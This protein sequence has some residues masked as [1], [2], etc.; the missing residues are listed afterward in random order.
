MTTP[1]RPPATLIYLHGH[2]DDPQAGAELVR[3]IAGP[4]WNVVLPAGPVDTGAGRRAWWRSDDDGAPVDDDVAVA[5]ALVDAEVR[6]HAAGPPVL[7]GGFSQGGA[8]ALALAL[9][10]QP[11]DDLADALAGAFAVGAWL[12]DLVGLETDVDRAAQRELPVLIAHGDDDEAV[13]IMLGRSAARLLDR[14]G[15]PATFHALDAGHVLAPF[16]PI[17]HDWAAAVVRGEAPADRR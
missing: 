10:A 12:P 6:R 17:V 4:T 8:L 13:P 7:L 9:R 15:V 3:S 2:D 16:V 14:R 1:A 11:P 5:V